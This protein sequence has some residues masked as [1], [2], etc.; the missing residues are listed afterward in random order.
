[1]ICELIKGIILKYNKYNKCLS[2]IGVSN[3]FLVFQPPV[4]HLFTAI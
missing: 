3:T 1:M 4:L 2:N